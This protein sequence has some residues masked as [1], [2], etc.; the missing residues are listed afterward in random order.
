MKKA[1]KILAGSLLLAVLV[2]GCE[3]PAGPA[4][5]AGAAGAD[6][7][8]GSTGP[9]GP[10]G[11]EGP[12]GEAG[13]DAN[14][15]CTQCH[16]ND[17]EL[18][19]KQVQFWN[20]T[21]YAGG[22]YGYGSRGDCGVCHAHEGFVAVLESGEMEFAGT[23]DPTPPNCRTC[24]VIHTTYTD[25]DYGLAKTTAVD[26]WTG[27]TVDFAGSGNLCSQCHQSRLRDPMPA[28]GSDPI[29][30]T[31][32]HY[33]PHYG[34]QGNMQGGVGFYDFEGDNGG[35]HAHSSTGCQQCHLAEGNGVDLGGHTFNVSYGEN[36]DE[37]QNVTGCN[38][39]CHGSVEDFGHFGLQ[40]SIH[41]K[42]VELGDMLIVIGI[43]EV[44]DDGHYGVV[45]GTFPGDVVAAWWN[46]AG[47]QGDASL[48]LH[49][50][51]YIR[52]LLDGAIDAMD[53]YM[54]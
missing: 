35:L 32:S 29:T 22:H 23:T 19:A 3:G 8:N 36:G 2:V 37:D 53:A 38:D 34:P 39:G 21:H 15:N 47:T 27:Q 31:S 25:A 20:S 12:A 26:F 18:F 7:S 10:A 44:D 14:E 40:T 6:G 28:F 51:K 13:T 24:H 50:P 16:T 5:P 52:G 54:P 49:N 11:P 30:F 4:G 42:M 17:T 46:L 48:G 45:P 43:A 33:G 9:A 1:F 41:D